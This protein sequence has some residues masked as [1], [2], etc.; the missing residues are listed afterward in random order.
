MTRK[1]IGGSLPRGLIGMLGLLLLIERIVVMQDHNLSGAVPLNWR[2]ARKEAVSPA[3]LRCEILCL[4]SSM[5][6]FGVGAR[7]IEAQTG[8]GAYNLATCGSLL[9]ANY[10]VLKEALAAGARP[11][12]VTI[13]CLNTPIQPFQIYSNLRNWPEILTVP[14]TFDL[15]WQTRDSDF[16]AITLL[17]R[18]FPSVKCRFEIGK[19]LQAVFRGNGASSFF[20]GKSLRRNWRAN[21]G[22]QCMPRNPEYE[23]KHREEVV[24]VPPPAPIRE[25]RVTSPLNDVYTRRFLDLAAAHK[26]RVFYLLP[27]QSPHLQEFWHR[28]GED[29]EHTRRACEAQ[30]H[31]PDLIVIDGRGSGYKIGAFY[32]DVHLNGHGAS[33]FSTEVALVMNRYLAGPTPDQVWV[34]LPPYRDL[35]PDPALEDLNVSHLAVKTGRVKRR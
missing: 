27:P 33:E 4:G 12:A 6:K 18:L 23:A 1:P 25:E 35:D 22:M 16:L 26:I 21:R 20:E 5:V 7:L 14:E 32:D 15:A 17:S 2:Y 10:F 34:N 28:S 3:V 30:A 8:K 24:P 13:D 29:I 11:K 19:N 31:Y 9:P